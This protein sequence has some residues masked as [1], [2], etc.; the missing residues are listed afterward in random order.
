LQDLQ[1]VLDEELAALPEWFR[2]VL[3][4]C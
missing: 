1:A 2:A 4:A 3:V